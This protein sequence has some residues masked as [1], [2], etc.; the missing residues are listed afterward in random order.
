MQ[1]LLPVDTVS[2]ISPGQARLAGDHVNNRACPRDV[3]D[4]FSHLSVVSSNSIEAWSLYNT[5]MTVVAFFYLAFGYDQWFLIP[6][7]NLQEYSPV[8]GVLLW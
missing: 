3:C 8:A 7:N 2:T 1:I 6:Q 4:V 5:D